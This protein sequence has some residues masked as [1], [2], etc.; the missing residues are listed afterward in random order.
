METRSATPEDIR[1]LTE[2][3]G[4]NAQ[5]IRQLLSH[6]VEDD[7]L[8][9]VI[10]ARESL[11]EYDVES[12]QMQLPSGSAIA[13]AYSAAGGDLEEFHAIIELARELASTPKASDRRHISQNN[14]NKTSVVPVKASELSR[15]LAEAIELYKV[16]Q[17]SEFE[18]D[19]PAG[20]D[21]RSDLESPRNWDITNSQ[22]HARNFIAGIRTSMGTSVHVRNPQAELSP[23]KIRIVK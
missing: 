21:D 3:Y 22:T 18:Y 16:E 10:E 5:L 1:I 15:S 8:D 14:L 9:D 7:H 23:V 19:C 20:D 6:G 12:C 13:H 11:G 4:T 2:E 17:L